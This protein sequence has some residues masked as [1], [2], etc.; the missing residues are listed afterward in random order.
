MCDLWYI[1]F[2]DN[3]FS[4]ILYARS[5]PF[6]DRFTSSYNS[7]DPLR[8]PPRRYSATFERN[9]VAYVWGG[10]GIHST[11]TFRDIV[12][13]FNVITAD[14]EKL[15]LY[16]DFVDNSRDYKHFATGAAAVMD[17]TNN[18][19]VLFFGGYRESRI[20]IS[21]DVPMY[22]EQYDFSDS[23]WTSIPAVVQS[24]VNE[25][26]VISPPKNRAFASAMAASNG[27]IYITGGKLTD[28]NG[29]TDSVIIW[30]YDPVHQLFAP[31]ISQED[32]TIGPELLKNVHAFILEDQQ[33]LYITG[34]DQLAC[35]FDP[36]ENSLVEQK[37]F[38]GDELIFE[39][40]S[41]SYETSFQ[42]WDKNL[43]YYLYS[44]I[45]NDFNMVY[46]LDIS[47]WRWTE[48][49][50]NNAVPEPSFGNVSHVANL[51]NDEH[52][53]M[54]RGLES[55]ENEIF[56]F[57]VENNTLRLH[58]PLLSSSKSEN[59]SSSRSLFYFREFFSYMLI[60]SSLIVLLWFCW[61]KDIKEVVKKV[62]LWYMGHSSEQTHNLH[63]VGEPRWI[64]YSRF[65][66]K[67]VL[68]FV[69]WAYFAYNVLLIKD[70]PKVDLTNEE[71][72][73]YIPNPDIRICFKGILSANVTFLCNKAFFDGK[74]ATCDESFDVPMFNRSKY[75]PYSTYKSSYSSVNCWFLATYYNDINYQYYNGLQ[76]SY[77]YVLDNSALE[78][79]LQFTVYNPDALNP[80][81][82]TYVDFIYEYYV[83]SETL[84][85]EL[86]TDEYIDWSRAEANDD[87]PLIEDTNQYTLYL[88]DNE[89]SHLMVNFE[90]KTRYDLSD[91]AWNVVGLASIYQNTEQIISDFQIETRNNDLVNVSNPFA[92]II[93]LQPSNLNKITLR[94]QRIYTIVNVLG[95]VGGLFALV[96]AI[97]SLL[98]GVR[99]FSP[100]GMVQRYSP[101]ILKSSIRKALYDK[102]GFLE[103]PIPLVHPVDQELFFNK[104]S[105]MEYEHGLIIHPGSS[106]TDRN[107]NTNYGITE[108]EIE[109]LPRTTTNS[110]SAVYKETK[111]VTRFQ[112]SAAA[113]KSSRIILPET[114]HLEDEL[115]QLKVAFAKQQEMYEVL[116]NDNQ[117][118]RR[119]QQLMEVMLK[120]YYLD[121]EVLQELNKAHDTTNSRR[122]NNEISIDIASPEQSN[123]TLQSRVRTAMQRPFRR[124]Q[125][126]QQTSDSNNCNTDQTTS[127]RYTQTSIDGEQMTM[128]NRSSDDDDK[129]PFTRD[130]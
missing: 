117:V 80:N 125:L 6:A 35:L 47:Q 9:N 27:N 33:I 55:N 118:M 105:L 65:L 30:K 36:S 53:F 99:P 7:S 87:R 24:Q 32:T 100:Y 102:F 91:S 23:Q 88:N 123:I 81:I 92:S 12:P 85:Q 122:N 130:I 40:M 71:P 63:R 95:S 59:S 127:V 82:L 79:S 26:T 38:G 103:R 70:S 68:S 50:V 67:L 19:R 128:T 101:K 56:T 108:D 76:V 43:L 16:Y 3:Y 61:K 18:D 93:K 119:R 74:Y 114:S 124:R 37:T 113:D 31:A 110:E 44:D 109:M 84:N 11:E 83:G 39:N 121:S 104:E 17:P 73:Q 98:Y 78:H 28:T 4:I 2:I 120:T 29:T 1:P 49:T 126:R 72:G 97:H 62:Y 111:A 58:R 107:Q 10:E 41:I 14:D 106:N 77:E 66:T 46:M 115:N 75:Y 51:Y 69:F 8:N 129:T 52:I 112:D 54:M 86:E 48:V 15:T 116:K 34:V 57:D 22:V 42:G 89:P 64:E 25:S 94:E 45:L 90:Y 13:Y 96:A 21:E 20:S 5:D 60:S